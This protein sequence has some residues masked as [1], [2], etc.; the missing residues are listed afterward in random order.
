MN[1]YTSKKPDWRG[2]DAHF[3]LAMLK[4][5]DI[6][7]D[8]L[9][10]CVNEEDDAWNCTRKLTL[11]PKD[12]TIEFYLK[13]GTIVKQEFVEDHVVFSPSG[14]RCATFA[15]SAPVHTRQFNLTS[16]IRDGWESVTIIAGVVY[17]DG[18]I[19]VER[20]AYDVARFFCDRFYDHPCSE[21][22]EAIGSAQE[23]ERK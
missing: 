4:T 1:H 19:V 6:Q 8:R 23:S 17:P 3:R 16:N 12:L 22:A 20:D 11:R 21:E 15:I 10:L 9:T 7:R 5:T 2:K 13:D 18:R 14:L